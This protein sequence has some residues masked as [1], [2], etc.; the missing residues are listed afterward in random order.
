MRFLVMA[1]GDGLGRSS[2]CGNKHCR[3]GQGTGLAAALDSSP[4]LMRS[5]NL[6]QEHQGVLSKVAWTLS[7]TRGCRSAFIHL[8]WEM[9]GA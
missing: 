8:G 2:G 5:S 7:S 9:Y 6:Q 3:A 1:P 4:L